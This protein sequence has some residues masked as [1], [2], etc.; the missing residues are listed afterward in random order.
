MNVR[1]SEKRKMKMIQALMEWCNAIYMNKNVKIRQLAALIGRLNFVGL[2][3][4]ETSLHLIDLDNEKI[5]AMKTKSWDDSMKINKKMMRELKWWIRRI[6][7][8]QPESLTNKI[9]KCLLTKDAS[10]QGWEATL[11]YN[12]E[13]D[14]IQHDYWREKEVEFTSIAKEIKVIYYGIIYYV[15]FL[16]KMQDQAI[17]LCSDQTTTVYDIWKWKANESL[18]ER[19]KKVIQLIQ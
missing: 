11:M 17:L 7:D 15:Q 19:M 10:L 13:V 3:I 4:Q 8:N 2:Q 14:L 18:I 16:K 12:N 9:V 6:N 5:N 1:I